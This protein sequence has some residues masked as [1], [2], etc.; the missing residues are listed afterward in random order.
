MRPRLPHPLLA[1]DDKQN[2]S[3]LVS[4]EKSGGSDLGSNGHGCPLLATFHKRTI[5]LPQTLNRPW[6]SLARQFI[7]SNNLTRLQPDAVLQSVGI[8]GD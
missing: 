7:S 6:F 8:L 5:H 4:L 2:Q 1:G 3:L